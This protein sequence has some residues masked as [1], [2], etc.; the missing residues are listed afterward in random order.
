MRS[1]GRAHE[2]M[3][4][5]AEAEPSLLEKMLGG[6][7]ELAE[8]LAALLTHG[9][10]PSSLRGLVAWGMASASLQHWHGQQ[11]LI[12]HGLE[13]PAMAHVRLQFETAI[14]SIWLL[15]GAT[16]DWVQRFAEPV[17]DG[18]MREPVMG[19]PIDS[20]LATIAKTE[21]AHIAASLGELKRLTW[22]AMNSYVHG[23][24]RPVVQ[25][26]AGGTEKQLAN[27]LLNANGMGV[28]VTNVMLMIQTNPAPTGG[29]AA[30]Q[31][32]FQAYLPP[33]AAMPTQSAGA[34][35]SGQPN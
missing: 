13:V 32:R 30:I 27:T 7:A 24:V 5:N 2:T 20:M 33:Q 10:P 19:P 8:A 15:R 31:R 9:G 22:T 6:S 26:M 29:L 11:L 18:D 16:N 1:N 3:A 28:M 4:M 14:R 17:P 34:R 21:P 12:A 35:P 23:G 25:A